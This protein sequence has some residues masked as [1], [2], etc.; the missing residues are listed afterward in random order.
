[1]S[2]LI[3]KTKKINILSILTYYLVPLYKDFVVPYADYNHFD[4][5]FANNAGS[6]QNNYILQWLNEIYATS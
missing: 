1:M 4:F 5:L 6:V 2:L 3:E